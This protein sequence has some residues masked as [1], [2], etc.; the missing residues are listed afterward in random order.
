MYDKSNGT[1]PGHIITQRAGD[2]LRN[3]YKADRSILMYM[4]M[5][6]FTPLCLDVCTIHTYDSS[7]LDRPFVKERSG[8]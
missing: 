2:V 4:P 1:C 5:S 8:L 7:S 6:N 3:K